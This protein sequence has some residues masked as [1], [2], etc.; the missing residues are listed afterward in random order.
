MTR[1]YFLAFLVLFAGLPGASP[2]FAQSGFDRP[3][4]DYTSFTVRSADP[5]A[6]AARCDRESRCRAWAFSYPLTDRAAAACW[7]KSRVTRPVESSCCVSG[8]KGSGVVEP[9]KG[10]VEYSTDRSGGDYRNIEVK[11]D[12]A[13]AACAE[14]CKGDNRCRAFTYVRPGYIGAAARCYLK[15]RVRPPRRKPCC[16][17]GVVR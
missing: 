16:V 15:E 13:G 7:L 5:A 2:A 11:P 9:R 10:A 14:A 12:A 17:S 6:C 4:G 8:V 1:L 3:G